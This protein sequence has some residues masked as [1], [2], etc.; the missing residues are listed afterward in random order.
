VELHHLPTR[1]VAAWEHT[2]DSLARHVARA[3]ESADELTVA[4]DT[5]AA[6]GDPDIL[7]PPRPGR[8]CSWCDF[9]RSCPEGGAVAEELEPWSMLAP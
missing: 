5:L 4:G 1:S 7:F 9:R 3:E 8:Q 6:G 2:D